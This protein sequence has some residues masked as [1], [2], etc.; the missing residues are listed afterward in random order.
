MIEYNNFNKGKGKM[1]NNKRNTKKT[2]K[3]KKEIYNQKHIR[4]VIS[5]K[6]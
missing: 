3:L 6:K 1:K 4:K 2:K 5:L